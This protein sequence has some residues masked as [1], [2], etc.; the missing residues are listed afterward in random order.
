MYFKSFPYTFYSLDNTTTVQVVTNLTTRITLT[1]EVKN[2]LSLFDEYDIKDG[3]TP[4]LV[5]EKFYGNPELHWLVL[6]YN[7]I[8]DPRFDWPLDTNNLN[9]YIAGK[10]ANVNAVHHY[11]DANGSYTNG[12]VYL[13]SS[14]DFTEFNIDDAI[15]NNTNTGSGY[16]TQKISSS[17]VRVTVT[18]GGFISGDRIKNISNTNSSANITSTVVLSGT[19]ITN[20]T[21]ENE[22]NESKRRIKI[23]KSS[24]VDAIV[25][26]FKK[27]LGE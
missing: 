13:V 4:E 22:V 26:D 17:N 9:R 15:T 21:Y 10:Y 6:H 1:D 23:L 25:V 27:K 20:Y 16:I 12:N 5:A 2:N 24:Y 7:E 18:T 8:I 3:E 11:E 19:P 14:S